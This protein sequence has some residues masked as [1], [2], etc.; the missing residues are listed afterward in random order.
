LKKIVPLAAACPSISL[1]I[2][3]SAFFGSGSAFAS[4]AFLFGTDAYSRR[5]MTV[6]GKMTLPYPDGLSSSRNRSAT[7]SMTETF[8][9]KLVHARVA[10]HILPRPVCNGRSRDV[11]CSVN[12]LYSQETG[13]A[14]TETTVMRFGPK[15]RELRKAKNLSLRALADVVG[16]SFTYISKI[17]NEKLDF[18]D[19]PGEELIAKLATALEVDTDDLL[20]LAK[21]IP[22]GIKKRVLERPDAFRR[23]AA[24][25][26]E[27]MD[28]LLKELE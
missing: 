9:W 23:F 8:T 20:I 7:D 11:D 21:K 18:G 27:T 1:R 28:R 6:S 4:T 14:R 2:A 24:L 12:V 17:E 5:R 22:E 13:L 3:S 15:I 19:Y 16:V 10:L 25:D 26:D